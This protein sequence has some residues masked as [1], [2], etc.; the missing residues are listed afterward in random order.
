M[1][2]LYT[3]DHFL[4]Q[5]DPSLTQVLIFPQLK[6]FGMDFSPS[7]LPKTSKI[8]FEKFGHL[9]QLITF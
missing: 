3:A 7:K 1:L 6:R 9:T 2:S 5:N 4:T 8:D